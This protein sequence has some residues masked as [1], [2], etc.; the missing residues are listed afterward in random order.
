MSGFSGGRVSPTDGD[1]GRWW[2]SVV[3]GVGKALFINQM[4]ADTT[5]IVAFGYDENQVGGLYY[6]S[7][8]TGSSSTLRAGG[9]VPTATIENNTYY[10]FL[11]ITRSSGMFFLIKGGLYQNWTL[12][13]IDSARA[14]T[15]LYPGIANN[16]ALVSGNYVRL[17]QLPVPWTDN[18]GIATQQL[19]GARSNG[20]TFTHEADCLIE[21]TLTT[22]PSDTTSINFRRQDGSNY[23]LL[24]I[25]SDGSILLREVISGSATTRGTA[26]VGSIANGQRIVIIAVGETINVFA[27]NALKITYT[28]ASNYKTQTS[29]KIYLGT[30]GAISDLVTW[31]RTLPGYLQTM[32]NRYAK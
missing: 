32:L 22:L 12:L 16:N 2:P 6:N 21:L 17:A 28:S 1:P 25:P 30:G 23:W 14:D 20:D 19:A 13:W 18:Y 11:A 5:K 9:G 7:F 10:S 26:A 8:Y 3:R 29:G 24:A 31:P 15:P 4:L 27:N